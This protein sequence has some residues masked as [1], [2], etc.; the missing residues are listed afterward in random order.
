VT[1]AVAPEFMPRVRRNEPMHRHTSWHVGGPAEVFFNPHS[2][3]DLAA[4]LRMLE[5]NVPIYW[6]GLGS[7]LLVRDGGMDGV[8]ISTHGALERLE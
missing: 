4:F 3:T 8:V 1:V 7:N 6:I 2:R 5:P